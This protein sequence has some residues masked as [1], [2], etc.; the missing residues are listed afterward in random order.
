MSV[1]KTNAKDLARIKAW[2]LANPDKVRASRARHSETNKA[3]SAKWRSSNRER[4]RAAMRRHGHAHTEAISDWYI[5]RMVARHN[6]PELA[7]MLPDSMIQ[8]IRAKIQ[9]ERLCRNLKTSKL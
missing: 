2:K 5:R 8:T 3:R 1:P 6:S 9:I 4:Y 7:A